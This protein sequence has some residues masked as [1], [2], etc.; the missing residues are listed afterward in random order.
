MTLVIL[1]A[2]MGSRFGGVKQ[3]EPID[4]NGNFIIDYSVFDAKR[5]GFDK[6]VFI[7]KEAIAEDFKST[8]G[9]R[10]EK[11]IQVEYAY[12]ELSDIPEGYT[13]PEGRVKPWGTTHAVRSTRGLVT[14]PYGVINADDFYGRNTFE[15]LAEHLGKLERG[16]LPADGVN[17]CCAIGFKVKNTLTDKG[18]C[19]RGICQVSEDGMLVDLVETHKIEKVGE[20]A[21]YPD[22]NGKMVPLDGETVVSMN[23]WGLTAE[24]IDLLD[25]DFCIFMSDLAAAP[26]PMKAESLLPS[27]MD[28]FVK[29]GLCDVR[30]YP[31]ESEWYGVTFKE[32]KPWVVSS[33]QALIDQGEYP[34]Q[35]WG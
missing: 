30:V 13:V 33:I 23:C 14:E 25:K 24:T 20:N 10:V 19:S 18:G 34:A 5:A 7:I 6:V 2:G 21:Q 35:L 31:T 3:M 17:H 12:Q 32:D 15:R 11:H 29:A 4:Q 9:A 22:S 26:D 28:T 1:A 16:E 27:S 8:I